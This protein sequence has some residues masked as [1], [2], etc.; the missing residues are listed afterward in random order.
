[1]DSASVP[2]IRH[3]PKTSKL[4]TDNVGFKTK[5]VISMRSFVG[6]L[7]SQAL[8]RGWVTAL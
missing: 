1:M 8:I 7:L 6:S 4:L 2:Y 5:L 3:D